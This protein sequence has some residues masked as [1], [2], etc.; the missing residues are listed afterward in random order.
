MRMSRRRGRK[1]R[2]FS[3][4]S[5]RCAAVPGTTASTIGRRRARC[6]SSSGTGCPSMARARRARRRRGRRGLS[7]P[8]GEA[9]DAGSRPPHGHG[10]GR[11]AHRRRGDARRAGRDL[12]RLRRRRR[13]RSGAA[14]PLPACRR[15]R[16]DHPH[17]G[18][19]VRRLWPQRRGG[20]EPGAARGDCW[21]R[22][23][24]APPAT[25]RSRRRAASASTWWSSTITWPTSACRRHAVVNP[26]RLDDLSGLGHLAAVGLVFMTIVAVNRVL[27][28]RASGRRSGASPTSS[29]SST[30]RSA[31]W[32]TWWR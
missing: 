1:S 30:G 17:P 9:A 29:A 6:R 27:R 2:S 12:R 23:I 18:P 20:A 21:S 25:S 13:D 5:A 22:S 8:D 31:P 7:R 15:P 26:N 16:S 11:R 19:P 3:T 24:A 28:T 10:R 4:S 32:P 14:R